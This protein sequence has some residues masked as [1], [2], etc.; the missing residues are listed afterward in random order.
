MV[1]IVQCSALCH[2]LQD[3]FSQNAHNLDITF[4]MS[5]LSATIYEKFAVE[6][7]TTLTSTFT[8]GQV[9]M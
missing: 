9:Q 2:S 4:R 5:T 6:M 8:V 3:I 1:A 7:F